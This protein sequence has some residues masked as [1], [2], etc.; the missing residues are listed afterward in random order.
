MMF[1]GDAHC[2]A[3]GFENPAGA[4]FCAG[5]G[6]ARAPLCQ[7][8]TGALPPG[9]KFCP[10]CGMKLEE[11]IAGDG[12]RS[13]SRQPHGAAEDGPT[14]QI[15]IDA[16]R[17]MPIP[18][19][20]RRQ[21]TILFADIVGSTAL[22][23]RMDPEDLSRVIDG[24]LQRMADAVL[25][26]GGTVGRM[27]GDG[28]LAYFG[29]PRSYEDDALRAVRCGIAIQESMHDFSARLQSAGD[30]SIQVRVGIDTGLVVVGHFG[31]AEHGEYTP[32]GDAANTAARL[33]GE[34]TPGE[35]YVSGE[36][37]RLVRGAVALKEVGH[38]T[39]KGKA[40]PVPAFAITG[41]APKV[42]AQARGGVALSEKG[43]ED[44][45]E[46]ISAGG[47]MIG[48]DAELAR[49]VA[50]YDDALAGRR[51]AWTTI[52]GES[53]VGKSRLSEACLAALGV[54]AMPPVVWRARAIARMSDAYSLVRELLSTLYPA[55]SSDA[56]DVRARREDAIARDL[57]TAYAGDAERAA[58][59]LMAVAFGVTDGGDDPRGL[60]E[61]ALAALGALVRAQAAAAPLVLILED[62]QWA[63][64]A[65]L[66]AVTRMIESLE[67]EKAL[68]ICNGRA[69]LIERRP[70]WGATHG[71]HVR[72]DL[73]RLPRAAVHRMVQDL[74]GG[75][76][77]PSVL[78]FVE[79]RS[80]GNPLYIEELIRMVLDRGLLTRTGGTWSA[81]TSA[82][83][84]THVPTTLLGLLQARLDS[85]TLEARTSVQH[86]SVIG[87]T[88]WSGAV[89]ALGK[90]S[91]DAVEH[92][93]K[94]ARSG[95]LIARRSRS[96]L[97]DMSEFVFRHTMLRD[98]AYATLLKR[99]RPELHGA[100]AEW[101]EAHAG[102]RTPEH[103]A[104]IAEHHASAGRDADAVRNFMIAADRERAVY[105]NASAIALYDRAET[106]LD[107]EDTTV[108]LA[109][110][111][112][113]ELALD[114][115]GDRDRQEEDL[116]TMLS[117]AA[118][119]GRVE[120]S[121]VR[122]RRSWLALR[123][124]NHERAELEARDAIRDAG[125]DVAARADALVNLG[126]A[127]RRLGRTEESAK[128]HE[129]ALGIRMSLGD[130][131]GTAIALVGLASALRLSGDRDAARSR[132]AD[133]LT[134]FREIGDARAQAVALTNLAILDASDSDLESA[135]PFF[136]EAL[137]AYRAAGDRIG[138][139][140][141]LHNLGEL[142]SK[143]GDKP[144][145]RLRYE[146][147]ARI[148]R[149]IG[150]EEEL[151]DVQEALKSLGRLDARET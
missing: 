48:R 142:S 30:P 1:R 119:L 59:A 37:E 50:L 55:E 99:A 65:S 78:A 140:R 26:A 58:S 134:I 128:C 4:K 64:D 43:S 82:L 84:A 103:A 12:V 51:A 98:A 7:R 8:C 79:T 90:R 3:C 29:A 149:Q 66:D 38:L 106:L 117:L 33:Q 62:L 81:D 5:C 27:M 20:E 93:L 108:R 40:E 109:L 60:A 94:T 114:T 74:I 63:D 6:R 72:I 54:H 96:S 28:L 80:E 47:E 100:A 31:G 112:G 2:D 9:S 71:Q 129:E 144:A 49:L 44:S 35:V 87:R 101:L 135:T 68:V 85:L 121:Y 148:Y 107:G 53:G 67:D 124:G 76:P 125:E 13:D 75:T 147:A 42:G 22:A 18:P 24:A 143:R 32:L 145:A 21:V 14:A 56:D 41:P 131:R 120:T 10:G 15:A 133:A 86:A 23:E 138:E 126:N 11:P 16:G 136:V 122:Y 88:F 104:R 97:P 132:Y 118:S 113:R 137:A 69:A 139:A 36:T 151:E 61:R 34:A 141:A 146:S 83:G 92:D 46:P 123:Q 19:T 25:D 115:L 116:D 91:S 45:S 105:A 102:D 77:P 89:E 39:M 127:V 150:D 110:L 17:A 95:G 52:I 130:R 73:S 57:A 111:H 70:D